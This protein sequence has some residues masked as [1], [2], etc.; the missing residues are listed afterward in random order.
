MSKSITREDV[1]QRLG[2]WQQRLERLYQQIAYWLAEDALFDVRTGLSVIMYQ[3]VM[4]Y[5]SIPTQELPTIDITHNNRLLVTLKPVALWLIGA[6]GRI[7]ILLRGRKI[8]FYLLDMAEPFQPPRWALHTLDD[9][10]RPQ[11][12]DKKTLMNAIL[13]PLI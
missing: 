9:T 13:K 8:S 7:D 4:M 5:F 1:E 2:D 6:N 10:V 12:F 11:P 3:E